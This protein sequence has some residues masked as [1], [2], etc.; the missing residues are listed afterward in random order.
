VGIGDKEMRNPNFFVLGAMKCG[1]TSLYA[2]LNQHPD[3]HFSDP[4]EPIFFEFEYSNGL[5]YYWNRYFSGW[6]GQS[7]VGEARHRNLYLPY[8]AERI[9]KVIP[10]PKF[11]VIVRDPIERAYSHWLH[12]YRIGLETLQFEDAIW[13]DMKRIER[14]V[15][16]EGEEGA[17][18]WARD[19][20]VPRGKKGIRTT[21]EFRT[22]VDSGYY[23]QQIRLYMTLFS[24]ER[25]KIVFAEDLAQNPQHVVSELWSFLGV[26]PSVKLVDTKPRNVS[27]SLASITIKQYGRRVKMFSLLPLRVKK[28][29]HRWIEKLGNHPSSLSPSVG[30][31]LASHYYRHNRDLEKLTGRDL[32]IWDK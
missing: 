12:N 18:L 13:E 6:R 2:Y 27:E 20:V 4:K 28:L 24:P 22:Y 1:T 26:E 21:K 17:E 7:V 25:I 29:G 30:Q 9:K 23:S 14:G 11:I 8:V 5:E 16:F 31:Y 19:L 15:T 3:V 32:A 10:N